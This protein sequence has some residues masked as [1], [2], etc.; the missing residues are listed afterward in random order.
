MMA[1]DLHS[2]EDSSLS[3]THDRH[4]F[5]N[6]NASSSLYPRQFGSTEEDTY[7]DK[8]DDFA[9]E[10]TR[11]MAH[12]MFQDDDIASHSLEMVL[13]FL[14]KHFFFLNFRWIPWFF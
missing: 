1:V 7:N 2:S 6:T 8:D 11:Q 9:A 12:F 14:S 3:D 13:P 5:P 10:L 4:H